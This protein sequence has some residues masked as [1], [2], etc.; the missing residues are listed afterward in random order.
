MR[1]IL[2]LSGFS[3]GVLN[4][5]LQLQH[6]KSLPWHLTILEHRQA[7]IVDI[8]NNLQGV[9]TC[10][11]PSCTSQGW[12]STVGIWVGTLQW[13]WTSWISSAIIIRA[14][15][16]PLSDIGFYFVRLLQKKKRGIWLLPVRDSRPST[17][18]GSE[19]SRVIPT[20]LVYIYAPKSVREG[21]VCP[22][23]ANGTEY[24]YPQHLLLHC[25]D[26]HSFVEVSNRQNKASA[27]HFQNV[28]LPPYSRSTLFQS[29]SAWVSECKG[30]HFSSNSTWNPN[31]SAIWCKNFVNFMVKYHRYDNP[32]RSSSFISSMSS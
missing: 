28:V 25:F 27:T 6:N 14:W 5:L 12:R 15:W 20:P 23:H 11:A 31:N 32:F 13:N 21:I 4:F 3:W 29:G 2:P 30:S 7:S 17:A 24:T 19:Q 16:Y 8:A 18:Y 10:S 1:P 9:K 26:Y 22:R